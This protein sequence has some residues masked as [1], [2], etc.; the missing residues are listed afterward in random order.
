MQRKKYFPE[1]YN[2]WKHHQKN[3]KAISSQ[4]CG[5][6]KNKKQLIKTELK[7]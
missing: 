4:I 1:N 7:V 5:L 2:P 6:E 3:L